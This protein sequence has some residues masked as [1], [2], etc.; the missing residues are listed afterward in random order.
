M[1]AQQQQLD[2]AAGSACS[3]HARGDNARFVEHE[4]VA[5]AQILRQIAKHSML[6]AAVAQHEQA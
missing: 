4:H 5:V 3:K 2:A 6:D 1:G